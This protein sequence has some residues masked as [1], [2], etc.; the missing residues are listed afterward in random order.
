VKVLQVGLSSLLIISLAAS[1]PG[2]YYYTEAGPQRRAQQP[3]SQPVTGQID[4]LDLKTVKE[5]SPPPE[6]DSSDLPRTTFE[7]SELIGSKSIKAK[8]A[9]RVDINEASAERLQTISGVG[10]SMAKDIINY[11]KKRKIR[12]LSD[13]ENIRGIGAAT[14]EK[15]AGEILIM[16]EFPDE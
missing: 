9:L 11:R 2:L 4:R 1:V 7:L 5:V 6:P 12:S 8:K 13:L 16:G 10:P 15:I 3:N 14:L